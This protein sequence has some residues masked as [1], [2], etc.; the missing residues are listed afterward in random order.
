MEPLSNFQDMEPA[1]LR[2]LLD[3][4]KKD[5]EEAVALGRPY[6]EINALYKA[7]KSAQ[8]TLSHKEAELAKTE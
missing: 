6:K 8:F 2:I 4:L 5:F 7:L 3:S 1:R